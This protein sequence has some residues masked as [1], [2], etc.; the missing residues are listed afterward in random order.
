M[1]WSSR[2]LD[3]YVL[4]R[5]LHVFNFLSRHRTG[6]TSFLVIRMWFGKAVE[7]FNKTIIAA[8]ANSQQ[9]VAETSNGFTSTSRLP[10]AQPFSVL[11]FVSHSDLGRICVLCCP[12]CIFT[13]QAARCSNENGM[14]DS[15]TFSLSLLDTVPCRYPT[16]ALIV[17]LTYSIGTP[18]CN[19]FAS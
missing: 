10:R 17:S 6:M 18:P 8:G 14:I 4:N 12:A 11:I 1:D 7:D 19:L 3:W 5:Y 15:D 13:R 16:V 2:F 9:L